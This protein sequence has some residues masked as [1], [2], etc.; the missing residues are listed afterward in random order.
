MYKHIYLCSNMYKHIPIP[1]LI[2][3]YMLG[4]YVRSFVHKK[5]DFAKDSMFCH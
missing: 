3:V 1:M 2:H 4:R 5:L